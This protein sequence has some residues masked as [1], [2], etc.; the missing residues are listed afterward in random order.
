MTQHNVLS[1]PRHGVVSVPE[2]IFIC[3]SLDGMQLVVLL[4][5][6]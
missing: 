6:A 5:C 4:E 3:I 1:Y 2:F